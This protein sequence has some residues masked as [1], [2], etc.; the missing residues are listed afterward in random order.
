[1]QAEVNLPKAFSVNDENE[2][3]PIQHLMARMNPK[4][5]VI[6]VATGTHK[7]GGCTVYWGITYLEGQRITKQDVE[8]ALAEAGFDFRHGSIQDGGLWA[9]QAVAG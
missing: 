8:N 9:E 7:R 1:M 6:E 4:L 2:F 5:M 3:F